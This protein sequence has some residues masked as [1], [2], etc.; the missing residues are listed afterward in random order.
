MREIESSCAECPFRGDE[1]ACRTVDG[2]APET[3]CATRL[4]PEAV[5]QALS[6]YRSDDDLMTFARNASLQEASC[7]EPAP[8]DPDSRVAVKPRIQEVMEFCQRQGYHRL[9][10]AF[11]LGLRNEAAALARI[12]ENHGFDLISAVCKVGC[13]DKSFLG[14]SD[15]E[16]IRPGHESM[17]NPIAQANILNE[18]GTQFNLVLGLCVGHDSMFFRYSK[19]PVTVIAVK[20]R[21]L[22]HNP[23]AALY[24][25]YYDY[26]K[27]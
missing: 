10:L 3:G 6:E 5:E 4:C 15:D 25:S 7:Y 8:N 9:G 23:L 20:D 24:S 26:L 11:C 18:A 13:V 22:G 2:R 16:K 1:R 17:C 19:A 12:F 27:K 14:I 21:V